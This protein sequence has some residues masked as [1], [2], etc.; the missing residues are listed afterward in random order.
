MVYA[1][2]VTEVATVLGENPHQPRSGPLLRL[3]RDADGLD[4][5]I[6]VDDARKQG[7][8]LAGCLTNEDLLRRVGTCEAAKEQCGAVGITR[9]RESQGRCHIGTRCEES[10]LQWFTREHG[11]QLA[12]CNQTG[13][14][15]DHGS[16]HLRGRIDGLVADDTILEIKH[17]MSKHVWDRDTLPV[18]DVQQVNLYMAMRGVR[19]AVVLEVFKTEHKTERKTSELVFDKAR[20]DTTCTRLDRAVTFLDALRTRDDRAE[21]LALSA[22]KQ[23]ESVAR[24]VDEN[25]DV[26]TVLAETMA[27]TPSVT[28]KRFLLDPSCEDL[29]DI[30]EGR[31]G[32]VM[33]KRARRVDYA[34]GCTGPN[35]AVVL[36]RDVVER[37]CNECVVDEGAVAAFLL[38]HSTPVSVAEAAEV[39]ALPQHHADGRANQ[40][41]LSSRKHRITGSIVGSI[42]GQNKYCKDHEVLEQ[43]LRPSWTPNPCTDYG[44]RNEDRAQDATLAYLR[45]KD[46]D[47]TI[48]NC[49]LVLCTREGLGW[50]GQSPDG[51]DHANNRLLEYKC[52]YKQR[53]L[54]SV[55]ICDLYPRERQLHAPTLGDHA[56]PVP[57]QYF[58]QV[59]W[60]ANL[61]QHDRILFVVWAPA[62]AADEEPTMPFSGAAA[63]AVVEGQQKSTSTRVLRE[64]RIDTGNGNYVI[65]AM[66]ATPH[67][68]IQATDMPRDEAWM[69]Y[70]LPVVRKFWERRYVP[71]WL[72]MNST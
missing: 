55:G 4:F 54:T 19:K 67:G 59:Q 11:V 24:V 38:E 23:S 62:G 5:C 45:L 60:G 58:C 40:A 72:R 68:L 33:T 7:N 25:H 44:N 1:F 66:V 64:E 22:E 43:L 48:A 10:A 37:L 29:R 70:A 14:T 61:N 20:W 31:G 65:E 42:L 47:A 16:W 46:P 18:Y 63:G 34:V 21:W 28:G 52:P 15:H 8:A 12:E 26:E 30:I 36:A 71:S 56:V 69:E 49:G 6:A 2:R 39:A 9:A 51:I 41:W 3:W 57:R 17:R 53:N 35:G 50:C 27:D 32:R 13:L